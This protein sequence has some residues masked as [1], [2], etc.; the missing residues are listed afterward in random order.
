ME[1]EED[2]MARTARHAMRTMAA[3]ALVP[4]LS[5]AATV[6][7]GPNFRANAVAEDSQAGPDVAADGAGNFVVVWRT[8][9]DASLDAILTRRFTS[10]GVPLGGDITV[11]TGVSSSSA[12]PVVAAGPAGDFLV[13]WSDVGEVFG[14]LFDGT[15]TP[16]SAAFRVNSH[17]TS[18]Q[19][20]PAVAA[21]GDGN[22]VVTWQSNFQDGWSYGVFMQ[23]YDATGSPLGGE[24]QV[25]T[26]TTS[27]QRYPAVAAD[28]A[29][30]FVIVWQSHYSQDG[31]GA[32]V[33]GQRYDNGGTPQGG[34]FLV[35]STTTSGQYTPSVAAA[36]AG[37]FI[38]AW[39]NLAVFLGTARIR[40]RRFDATGAPLGVDFEVAAPAGNLVPLAPRVGVDASG[41]SLIVWDRMRDTGGGPVSISAQRYESDG[42]PQGGE[43]TVNANPLLNRDGSAVAGA[44]AGRFLVVWRDSI[45]SDVVA[46]RFSTP[47]GDG[48][49]DV[50]EAC[51]DGDNI[52]GDGCG[53]NCVIEGCFT[54]AGAPSSCTPIVACAPDGCCA[55]GCTAANDPDCPTLVTG[56]FLSLRQ[57]GGQGDRRLLYKSRDPQLDTTPAGG[58]DPV[59]DGAFLQVYNASLGTAA[60][61]DLRTNGTATWEARGT[62]SAPLF[63]YRDRD[64]E[65]GPCTLARVK[66][67]SLLRV[68]CTSPSY[69]SGDYDLG[70]SPQGSVAVRFKSGVQ[71]YCG[72]FGGTIVDDLPGARFAA[73]NAPAPAAC[74][75][76]PLP[77]PFHIDGP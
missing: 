33:F 45:G 10:T 13:V 55:P 41:A 18:T 75:V 35:N 26:W 25:N 11:A 69:G 9:Y 71:E 27:H 76:P 5:F 30:D 47:C 64:G 2:A 42:T 61:F 38:V 39:R 54:C 36:P 22:F 29:G 8:F 44:G 77:C 57:D 72:L 65:N 40:A 48:S 67:A 52:D 58:I 23:R 43:L 12:R 34:E 4:A 1:A 6:P 31:D 73:R 24:F 68:K 62:P 53:A 15:G 20:N 14:R 49:V 32:G 37:D 63:V 59:A 66:N 16:Q 60:C 70:A 50:G 28:A 56:A 19:N 51:D 17:S 3:L 74:P 21:G 7:T 46:Q